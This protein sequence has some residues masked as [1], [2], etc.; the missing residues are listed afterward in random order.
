MKWKQV[1]ARFKELINEAP[2]QLR[3]NSS[4]ESSHTQTV[5]KTLENKYFYLVI[6][7]IFLLDR[8]TCQT[9]EKLISGKDCKTF[10]SF[11]QL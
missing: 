8:F 4:P 3:I 10:H 5:S 2:E 7:K 11:T 9:E 1:A 6:I